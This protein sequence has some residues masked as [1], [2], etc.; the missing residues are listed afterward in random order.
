MKSRTLYRVL[1]GL[2]VLIAAVLALSHITTL[3][4]AALVTGPAQIVAGLVAGFGI[5]IVASLMGVAGG[6]RVN[7]EL[8]GLALVEEAALPF[9]DGV[10]YRSG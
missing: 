10:G 3:S 5:G 2:L 7:T 8:L 4:P 1:A 6:E 9:A